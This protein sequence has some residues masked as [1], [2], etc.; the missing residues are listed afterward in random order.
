MLAYLL[1]NVAHEGLG[2]GGVCLLVG[3]RPLALSSAWFDGD[4]TGVGLWG[5]RAEKAGGTLANL[6]VGLTLWGGLRAA[7]PR[8]AHVYG[9]LWLAMTVN[10]LQAGGYLLVSPLGGFGDW[11]EFIVGLDAPLVWRLG[12]TAT[13]LALSSLALAIAR[14]TV[15]PLLGRDPGERR[16]RVRA[17]CWIPYL[18]V[19]GGVFS[20]A[21]LLNPGGPVFFFTSAA[22]HLGG[23]A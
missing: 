14:A 18:F 1:A 8:S 4:L 5:H 9:F 2:H 12:L 3:G 17:L 23:S 16:R 11:K 20:V 10:L 6:A 22:A 15:E 7:R 19:G 13:G 21:A